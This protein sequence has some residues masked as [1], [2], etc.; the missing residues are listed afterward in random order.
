MAH[1]LSPRLTRS[2]AGMVILPAYYAASLGADTDQIVQYYVDICQSSPVCYVCFG[3]MLTR[4]IPIL[5]YN[6]PSNAAGLDM[7]SAVIEKV[8]RKSKNLCGV[9]L[10]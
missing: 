8:M 5:L 10:T 3:S 7:S 9:K 2:D 1:T 4:Q 6:F